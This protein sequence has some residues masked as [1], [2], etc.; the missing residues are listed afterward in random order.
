MAERNLN[1]DKVVNRKNTR[2]LKYDFAVKRGYPEDILPL[3]V[4]D[5][6]FQTTSYVEDALVE[7][8]HHNIYGYTNVLEG[9]GFFEAVAAW[10]KKQ[11]D[12]DVEYS[13]LV[14]TPGVTLAISNAV[15]AYTKPGDAVII[16]QP[17]YYPFS[18][19]IR[20]N[21]R[22]MVSSDLVIDSDG[23]YGIDFADFEKKI[24]DYEVKMYILCNPH[25][26]VGRVWTKEEL[27]K[28]GEIC[29]KHNVIVFSDE[30]HADFIWR[31]EHQIFQEIDPSFRDFTVTATA[32]SKTFN[33]AGLQQS[34]IFIS[35][36]K[37]RNKFKEALDVT[38]LDEPNVAGITAS[39]AAYLYG[40]EWYEAMKKYVRANM[41]YVIA[42]VNE[43]LPQIKVYDPEGTYL[44]WLDFRGLGLKEKDLEKLIVNKAGLW[45]DAG[46]IFGTCGE[47]F[48]RINV[49]CPRAILEE[50][51]KR[52]E[53]AVN[54]I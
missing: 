14:K 8:A 41:D 5:M 44:M 31:G 1:F 27:C 34:N 29:R 45:L 4:A 39:R 47:G 7:L 3:W 51:M 10:M 16:N 48:E 36:K 19:I 49:A 28:L 24:I 13:W 9:D 43:R 40:D 54:G 46:A 53:S 6:D 42:F 33:L 11:H 30:I 26:P 15:R 35:D 38:G 37:L 21:G 18:N 52:I 50:A 20:Q 2:C 25:N 12:W 23:H 22:V 17:V 32:P